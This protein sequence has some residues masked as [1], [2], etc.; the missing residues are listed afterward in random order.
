MS[1]TARAPRR[2]RLY[3]SRVDP[4]SVTKA[5]FLLSLTLGIVLV[6]AVVALWLVLNVTG[7]FTSGSRTIGEGVGTGSPPFS[8]LDYIGLTKVLGVTLGI[9]SV[10][11]VL[12]TLLATLLAV[13]YNVS[14]GVTGGVE[15]V[16]SDDV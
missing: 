4:W 5:A 2:A 8:L 12:M 13:M 6:V 14:T 16:L 1:D 7:V 11:I 3:V 10:E 9:A 15:V